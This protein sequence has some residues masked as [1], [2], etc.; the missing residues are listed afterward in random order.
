MNRILPPSCTVFARP[1]GGLKHQIIG[2][3][4]S[5]R[6]ALVWL[7]AVFCI[8]SGVAQAA[9]SE[10]FNGTWSPSPSTSYKT[11]TVNGWTLT[12]VYRETT[13]KYEG[14]AAVRFTTAGVGRHIVS[15]SNSG[16]IGTVS[17]WHREWSTA[18]GK[19]D[20]EVYISTNGT[21]W[22]S[23]VG[24][25]SS[26]SLTY[27]QYSVAVN[28]AA[29]K[30]V[31]IGIKSGKRW[32]VDL[33]E[34]SDAPVVVVPTVTTPTSASITASSATLGATVTDNGGAAL[35]SRGTVW[36][37]AAS[38][39]GN[40]LAEG[41]T[42]VS[43]FTHSRSS[44]P[45]DTL[46]YFRGYAVNSA[47]TGYS[48]DGTF[49]TLANVP[50]APTVAA[51]SSSS[52]SVD[53][54]VNGNPSTT[55]FAIYETTQSKY[56]QSDGTL[57]A[58]AYWATDATWGTKSVTGLGVNQQYTFKVKARNGAG[59]PVE[60]DFSGTASKYTLAAVPSAPTV[61]GATSSS[62]DVAVNENGNPSGTT[63]AIQRT[64]DSYYLKADGTWQ[65]AEVW[66]TKA[67]W[68]T[69]TAKDLAASTVYFFKVKAKNGDG[70]ETAFSSTASGTTSASGCP[71]YWTSLY[72]RGAPVASYVLGD[73]L[74]YVFEFAINQDTTGWTVDWGIG[75]TTGGSGWTWRSGVWSYY[76]DPNRV[77]K[78]ANDV[79]Q[80]TSTGN[81]YYAGRFITGGCTYYAMDNWTDDNLTLTAVNYFTVNALTAPS[82]CTAVKDTSG[83]T[84][85]RVD[86]GWAQGGGKNVLIT[87]APATPTGG[88][89]QGTGYSANDTFGNQTVI[90]GSQAGTSLEVTGLTPG[91]TYYFTFYSENNSYYSTAV[92]ASAVTLNMP[93]ARN[94]SG[95]A[96]PGAPAGTIYLGDTGKVFT[97][98][99]WGTVETAWG[100]GRLWL[101]QGN[102]DLS[103]GTAGAWGGFTDQESKSV[104][105]GVFNATGTWYWG[106]QMDYGATYG[107][108]FWYKA[109]SASWVN[110][111]ANGTGAGLTVT[112]SAIGD[113]GSQTATVAS[114]TQINLSWAKNAVGHNVMVVRSTDSSFTAP[115]QG[116][117]Y[118]AGSSTIGG[119]LVIYNGNGTSYNDTGRTQGTMYYYKFY[120][121]NNDYYSAGVTANATTWTTPTVSTTSA[122]PGTPADPTQAN[123]TG[124]VTAEGGQSVTERG[125]VW[126]TTGA[127]TT[128]NTKVAHASGGTGSFTVTLTSLTPGQKIYY[129]AYAINS[130]G[131]AYG[132]T[133]D[134]T[135]DCFTNG[136]GILAASAV[137]ATNFTANW[138][139][140]AGA[141]G[142]RI[143]VSTNATFGGAGGLTTNLYESFVDF[144][145]AENTDISGSLNTYTLV[146]GWTGTKVY[147]ATAGGMAKI[148]AA[149][150]AGELIT[151][152]LN[153]SGNG[154]AA[155]LTYDAY[156][157]GSDSAAAIISVSINGGSSYAIVVTNTFSGSMTTYTVELTGCTA[158]TK[159]K[160]ASRIAS[161]CRFYLDNVQVAQGGSTPDYVSGYSNLTVSAGTSCLVT[162]LTSDVKYFYRVRAV[163]DYCTSTNSATTNVTTVAATANVVLGDNGTQVV[164]ARVPG[165]TTK[166][167][168]H[169]FK[170][171]VTVAKA[172]LAGVDFTT[173]G[174]YATADIGK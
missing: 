59:T 130:V 143:D 84:A 132:S 162:G 17:F 98:E 48:A 133:L 140:V 83:N 101:R 26:T 154:G 135:A 152:S 129:R 20:F 28:N 159:I 37:T 22:S 116:T 16:G 114:T 70:T 105:S 138:S 100:Q 86:L 58:S 128:A 15:P 55:T 150:T 18:D 43:A 91:A 40:L 45:V 11:Y 4:P 169:Q 134:F 82:S 68:G 163:N 23:A 78:S 125:I 120:S 94:T 79:H 137:T 27:S 103:G 107:T 112:V 109:S 73:Y 49:R 117:A 42:A 158:T 85:T 157:Y 151:P 9:L 111:A 47:G 166:L 14:A 102:A 172:T 174:T 69:T 52:V 121:V 75:S 34:V 66:Q 29:A 146:T 63:F 165:G 77:W 123:A 96:S 145:S 168:L 38:P 6:V 44:L 173:A 80:F 36:G 171:A 13:S 87:R 71:S 110:L 131:T 12:S 108:N 67:A 95:S 97:F 35:S 149:S 156:S 153:L 161:K 127:P 51:V 126:N 62:L 119:D 90:A 56:V 139:A 115:T 3:T 141:S 5:W 88:P 54:N 74:A 160:I 61:N 170:L 21:A 10:G 53:V 124:N 50:S 57:G 122:T 81:F 147:S 155:T 7:A 113:P 104:T 8:G 167:I 76:S 39:T 118:T 99:S 31:K 25:G 136:P 2:L 19:V 33:V 64:S 30:Y 89:T 93:Q 148:G 41:G 60:T 164:A 92:T 106:I 65:A 142:Y 1:R 144:T 32:L 24:S 46:I 72:N